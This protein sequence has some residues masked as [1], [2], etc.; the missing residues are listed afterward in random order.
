MESRRKNR[1]KKMQKLNGIKKFQF[2][3][4]SLVESNTPVIQVV[5]KDFNNIQKAIKNILDSFDIIELSDN[6]VINLKEIL[7]ANKQFKNTILFIDSY[8]IFGRDS[9]QIFH[10]LKKN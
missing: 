9:D 7:S 5:S 2:D 3:L 4:I 6:L 8:E 10:L 1:F